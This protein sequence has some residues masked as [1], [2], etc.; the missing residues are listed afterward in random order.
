MR[1]LSVS[2]CVMIQF[3]GHCQAHGGGCEEAL[4]EYM[5]NDKLSGSLLGLRKM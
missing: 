5:Y 3:L 1:K 2:I 4:V